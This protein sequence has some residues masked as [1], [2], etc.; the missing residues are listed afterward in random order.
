ME[1]S[2]AIATGLFE[3]K[4]FAQEIASKKLC[5]SYQSMRRSSRVLREFVLYYFSLYNLSYK[6]FFRFY[7]ILGFVEALVYETDDE[8]E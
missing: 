5:I 2:T 4:I 6:D 3:S 8:V 7:P 1:I